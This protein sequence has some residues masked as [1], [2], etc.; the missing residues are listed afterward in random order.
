MEAIK[1]AENTM[2]RE[3]M[4]RNGNQRR[5]RLHY[6]WTVL[7]VGVWVVF[8][9]I[10]LARFGYGLLLPCMQDAL[11]LDN[12]GTGAFATV[13]LSG[14]LLFSLICGTLSSRIGARLVITLGLIL[15]SLGMFMTGTVRQFWFG[16]LALC[17]VGMG[18][19]ATNVPV[20]ALFSSWFGVRLRGLAAGIGV[21]GSSVAFILLGPLVP[22]F[23]ALFPDRGWRYTWYLFGG[24]SLVCA[25]AAF[26][27]LRDRPSQMGLAPLGGGSTDTFESPSWGTM[28]RSTPI[29]YLGALYTVFGFSYIIYAT[30]F[31][32]YL[33]GEMNISRIT[34]GT[35][36]MTIGWF[37][38][39]CGLLWSGLSD[40]IGRGWALHIVYVIQVSA[41]VL[42]ALSSR[43]WG[44]TLSAVL[45]GLTAWS[46]PAI[47]SAACG[48]LVGRRLAPA[49]L[50]F[51][52][53]FF[54]MGQLLGPMVAGRIADASGSFRAAFLLAAGVTILG[55]I[56][57]PFLGSS[58]PMGKRAAR[59]R[60]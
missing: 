23:I 32:R 17:V 24:A 44:L 20:M 54:G 2:A 38:L 26:L 59:E 29:W 58:L 19:G 15:A 30:Y 36:Y 22:R 47:V 45:F 37:S 5:R 16:L 18:S 14:Y 49:A 12:T 28:V 35:L 11:G 53:I 60:G 27:L 1:F 4:P 43:V 34:A 50:G 7:A 31:F 25:A 40:R 8:I 55:V 6:A 57:S 9:S 39:A 10:G 42:F 48:D 56:G 13:S 46:T 51:A 52:T 33:T 41:Y 3:A 21:T